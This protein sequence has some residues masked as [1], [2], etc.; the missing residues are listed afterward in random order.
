MLRAGLCNVA[1]QDP[2]FS[3]PSVLM[4]SPRR[5][6]PGRQVCEQ[7]SAAIAN[8]RNAAPPRALPQ[9]QACVSA[10]F[11]D[12]STWLGPP[13][14]SCTATPHL[15]GA[16][17]PSQFISSASALSHLRQKRS[18]PSPHPLVRLTSPPHNSPNLCFLATPTVTASRETL[19]SLSR[20]VAV[21]T[22]HSPTRSRT[23]HFAQSPGLPPRLIPRTEPVRR[24]GSP[25]LGAI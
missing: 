14:S 1:S 2:G 11:L 6:G 24:M 18:H 19:T 12:V 25:P 16:R 8:R 21:V 3:L 20:R 9:P 23:T 13:S 5:T 10:L 15:P 7:A 22:R 4:P 17:T